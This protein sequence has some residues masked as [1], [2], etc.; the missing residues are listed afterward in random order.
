MHSQV[1][2]PHAALCNNAEHQQRVLCHAMCCCVPTGLG[3]FI[4]YPGTKHGFAVRG[5]KQDPA[6]NAARADALK[7]GLKFFG[8]H[9]AGVTPP[10]Q[11]LD[12]SAP[13]PVGRRITLA[14]RAC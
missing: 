5:N 6:V 1:C 11:Q 7:Q 14:P 8:Q 4:L 9:L 12:E 13:A 3:T 2:R 10:A